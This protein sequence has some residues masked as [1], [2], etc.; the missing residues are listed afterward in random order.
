MLKFFL[1]TATVLIGFN[2]ILKSGERARND[3][4]FLPNL[5]DVDLN[6][7]PIDLYEGKQ[8][9]ESIDGHPKLKLKLVENV[10]EKIEENIKKP[11]IVVDE[12]SNNNIV[13]NE[14]KLSSSSSKYILDISKERINKLFDILHDKEKLFSGVFK[15][16][17]LIV[18]DNLISGN[19]EPALKDFSREKERFLKV[20]DNR[21]TV[22]DE[23]VSYLHN[24]S[25]YYSFEHPRNTVKRSKL[26]EDQNRPVFVTAA[27]SNYY[28]PLQA[29]IY[30][31]H[32]NLPGYDIIVYDLGLTE[33]QYNMV[34]K[35]TWLL[36]DLCS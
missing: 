31:L 23:F 5:G 11:E 9:E 25:D 7:L 1:V 19:D 15:S 35:Y 21:V 30:Q 29:T 28:M 10:K 18:F 6:R 2:F 3:D 24:L 34:L 36:I 33:E 32:R 14:H 13:D 17:G 12:N 16:L 8:T 27:N 26:S 4:L 20:V 22:T